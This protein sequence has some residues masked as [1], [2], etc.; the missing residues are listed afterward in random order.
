MRQQTAS[1]K[2]ELKV[3]IVGHGFVGKAM[4]RMFPHALIYDPL[5]KKLS[6]PQSQINKADV[7]FVCVPTPMAKDGSCDTSIVESTIAWLDTSIIIIRSTVKPG[8]TEKLCKLYPKKRIVFMPEYI[9]ET[10]AHP[11]TDESLKN[12]L[13]FGGTKENCSK[14]I[15]IFQTVY[16]SSVK[17]LCVSATEA[18]IIK[19]MANTAA[20]TMVTLANEFYNI[21][22]AF[23][24]PYD[25]VREGFLLDPR[26]SRY[27]TFVFPEQR[28]FGGK[29]LPKDLNAIIKAAQQAGYSPEFVSAILIN[30][31]RVKGIK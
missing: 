21:C 31:D 25:M 9:G 29:C 28:G 6:S 15:N 26:M 2:K 23:G 18:E 10:T 3:A 8:T 22:M 16:N 30:N 20:A 11:F 4:K 12:F 1:D 14:S 17:I 5:E 24:V 27:F 19:Y 13:I 7:G